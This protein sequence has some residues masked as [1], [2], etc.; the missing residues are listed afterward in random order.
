MIKLI[1]L[2]VVAVGFAFRM[3]PLL[4]VLAAGQ[5]ELQATRT[6]IFYANQV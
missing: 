2:V 3:N 5:R 1:G 6:S 4:V